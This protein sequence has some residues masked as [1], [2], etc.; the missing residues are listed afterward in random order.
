MTNK[1][2]AKPEQPEE[3]SFWLNFGKIVFLVAVLAA[4]WFILERLMGG[5]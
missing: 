1:E 2:P 5:K 4:A 3:G